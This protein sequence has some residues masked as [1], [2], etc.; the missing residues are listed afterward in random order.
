MT[1]TSAV[2]FQSSRDD[3]IE[4]GMS[5]VGRIQQHLEAK[6]VDKHGRIV[7]RGEAGELCTRGY[8]VMLGYWNDEAHTRQALDEAGWMHTRGIAH[9]YAQR[10]FPNV[11]RDTE[12]V[13]PRGENNHT[14]WVREI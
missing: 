1:E 4:M 8:S 3:P 11:R 9:I 7:P 10:H 5:T 6:V 12:P 14:P 13:I 2:S